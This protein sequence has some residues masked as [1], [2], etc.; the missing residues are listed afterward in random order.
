MAPNAHVVNVEET[1]RHAGLS[2]SLEGNLRGLAARIE[3]SDMADVRPPTFLKNPYLEFRQFIDSEFRSADAESDTKAIVRAL[4]LRSQA[5]RES[6]S[7]LTRNAL[8]RAARRLPALNQRIDE[9]RTKITP[10]LGGSGTKQTLTAQVV[11]PGLR[12]QLGETITLDFNAEDW[13]PG[14]FLGSDQS[15]LLRGEYLATGGGKEEAPLL[16]RFKEGKGTVIFTSFHNEKQNSKQEELLLRNLVFTTVTARAE[17]AVATTMLSGGFPPSGRNVQSHS[18]GQPSVT[19][20]YQPKKP[21][22]LRFA[23]TFSGQGAAMKFTL[24]APN[25][26]TFEQETNGT[27]I[28]EATGAPL[29]EWRYTVTAVRVPYENF[30]Y[31]VSVGESLA[32]P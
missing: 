7:K 4:G 25:G 5:I 27:M 8:E 28:V 3:W 24:M 11:D 30:P 32:R 13:T 6:H 1:L 10:E 26:Q 22:P 12:E 15:V 19:R 21:G 31:S 16:V 2:K 18:M 9:L 29:G 17:E 14:N 20:A 23:L